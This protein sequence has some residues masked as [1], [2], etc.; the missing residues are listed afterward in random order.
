MTQE[1]IK[2]D[3]DSEII[4]HSLNG[5]LYSHYQYKVWKKADV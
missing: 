5:T 3:N 2:K 4:G 1:A